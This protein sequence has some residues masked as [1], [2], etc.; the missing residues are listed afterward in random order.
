MLQKKDGRCFLCLLDGDDT[1]K[2]TEEHHVFGGP[3]RKASEA[4]G[5][6]VYLCIPHHRTGAAAVHRCAET[7]QLLQA[8]AQITWEK[9]HSREEWMQLMGKNYTEDWGSNVK[10]TPKRN[11]NES[12]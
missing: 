11:N 3:R 2:Q 1:K 4:H 8:A 9:T 10:R 7:R 6:K 12:I 5:L